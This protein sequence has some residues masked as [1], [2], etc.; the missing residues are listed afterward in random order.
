M[1]PFFDLIFNILFFIPQYY[2]NFYCSII[3][4]IDYQKQHN[5]I[6]IYLYLFFKINKF[7]KYINSESL[8]L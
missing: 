3:K 2:K 6:L 4:E 7:K 5:L 1:S 8:N